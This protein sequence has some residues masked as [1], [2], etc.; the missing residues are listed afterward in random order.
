MHL[1]YLINFDYDRFDKK[2]GFQEPLFHFGRN[3]R[4]DSILSFI[5]MKTIHQQSSVSDDDVK[6]NTGRLS[7]TLLVET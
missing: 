1:E 6:R 2:G 3:Q 4:L 5:F 7:A